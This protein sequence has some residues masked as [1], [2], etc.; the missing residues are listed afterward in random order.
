MRGAVAVIRL[1]RPAKRNALSDALVLAL[2]N[3]METLPDEAKAAVLCG[4]GDH[5]CAGLDL[6]EIT[7][8]DAGE[9][10]HH[11]RTWH[12]AL[13]RVQY[14]PVPV[15]AAL[16][17]AVVGGG[18]DVGRCAKSARGQGTRERLSGRSRR[19]GRQAVM[20]AD[21]LILACA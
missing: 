12:A 9:S 17:G 4:E 19:Q 15:V 8:R 21:F 16:Q 11:S 6:S 10:M 7:E 18:L 3:R 13:E 1:A 14:G 5:F 2:R 20:S